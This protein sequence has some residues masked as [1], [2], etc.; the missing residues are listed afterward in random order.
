M[1]K[2]PQQAHRF[3]YCHELERALTELYG[4]GS[5]WNRSAATFTKPNAV[6][7]AL[8]AAA[9][10]IRRR[11]NDL[12]TVDHRLNVTTS[13]T[14]TRLEAEAGRLRNPHQNDLEIVATLLRLVAKLLGYDWRDGRP[15]RDIVYTQTAAQASY[16]DERWRGLD[17]M[18]ECDHAS[19]K[20]HELVFALHA[21]KHGTAQIASILNLPMPVV[22]RMLMR[23][24]PRPPSPHAT[25]RVTLPPSDPSS[26]PNKRIQRTH[27][28]VTSRA[29]RA[30]GP[31]HAARR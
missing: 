19:R 31:R 25:E 27:S 14:L 29:G 7:D 2:L 30:H 20:R 10:R 5:R 18:D 21:E 28:R 11:L 15:N 24:S 4:R 6:R 13:F 23:R 3:H 17:G 12:T 16:D 9:R 8:T 1:S 22:K 26:R